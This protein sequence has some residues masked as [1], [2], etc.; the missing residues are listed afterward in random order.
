MA[1]HDRVLLASSAGLGAGFGFLC[2]Q[3]WEAIRQ[4]HDRLTEFLVLTV[5]LFA[6]SALFL[7]PLRAGL[8]RLLSQGALPSESN[9]LLTL[10]LLLVAIVLEE[11]FRAAAA[12]APVAA[13]RNVVSAIVLAGGTTFVW[14][15]GDGARFHR[16]WLWGLLYGVLASTAVTLVFWFV[17]G[18]ALVTGG[19]LMATPPQDAMRLAVSNG[20]LFW[21]PLGL[22]GGLALQWSHG[23]GRGW[24]IGLAILCAGFLLDALL[25]PD[26]RSDAAS[27]LGWAVALGLR[28]KLFAMRPG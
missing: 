28:G 21:G 16:A 11:A 12:S 4:S 20:L 14:T 9:L 22:I 2:Y 1:W 13:S 23:R 8:H 3:G 24:A 27:N 6:I 10:A 15:L 18:R 5:L 26:W 25:I 7:D 17:H 19:T